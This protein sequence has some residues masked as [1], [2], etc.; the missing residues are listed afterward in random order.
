[1]SS[2]NGTLHDPS[3]ASPDLDRHRLHPGPLARVGV[4]LLGAE[5]VEISVSAF[6]HMHLD[7]E[8]AR[9]FTEWAL[10]KHGKI[11]R[12]ASAPRLKRLWALYQYETLTEM[13][14]RGLTTDRHEAPEEK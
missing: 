8:T 10:L 7:E 4:A 2:T 3:H 1:L 9:D 6:Q 11:A 5:D 12:T 13:H 14:W